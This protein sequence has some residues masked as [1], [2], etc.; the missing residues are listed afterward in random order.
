[1]GGIKYKRRNLWILFLKNYYKN[2]NRIFSSVFNYILKRDIWIPDVNIILEKTNKEWLD[3][4]EK[5]SATF[6]E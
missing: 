4:H 3:I 1:M 5:F 6:L 2:P